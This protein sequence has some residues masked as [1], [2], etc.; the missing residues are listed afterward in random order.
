MVGT[1]AGAPPGPPLPLGGMW[2]RAYPGQASQAVSASCFSLTLGARSRS[3]RCVPLC[4]MAAGCGPW[5]SAAWSSSD[6]P[7]SQ[8]AGSVLSVHI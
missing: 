8:T 4:P 2:D 5:G 7:A 3:G 6:G 1:R